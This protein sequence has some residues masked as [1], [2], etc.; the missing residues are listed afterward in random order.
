MPGVSFI[1]GCVSAPGVILI[2]LSVPGLTSFLFLRDLC[3]R[4]LPAKLNLAL[5]SD[6]DFFFYL[7]GNNSRGPSCWKFE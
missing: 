1:Q 4:F 2:F 7:S 3:F 6:H 5:F